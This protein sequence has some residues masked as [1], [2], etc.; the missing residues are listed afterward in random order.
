MTRDS[1]VLAS[2]AVL[3]LCLI[4]VG[5]SGGFRPGDLKDLAVYTGTTVTAADLMNDAGAETKPI[6][7]AR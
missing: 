2:G 5:F 6:A 3:A 7:A 4:V 1:L